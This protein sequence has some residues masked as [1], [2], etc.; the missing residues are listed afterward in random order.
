MKTKI[1]ISFFTICL[2]VLPSCRINT[3]V[4]IATI[5]NNV[6]KK[7]NGSVVL[8]AIFVDTRFTHPWSEYDIKSTLDSIQKAATWIEKKAS[9]NG[10]PVNINVQYHQ[11]KQV[12]PI[13]CEFPNKT[14]SGTLYSPIPKIGVPKLNR[15]ADRIANTAGKSLSP[16]TSGVIKTKN[17]RNDRERLISHLRNMFKTDNVVL[18]YFINNY[19]KEE[20]SLTLHT[21]SHSDIEYS[22]VSFKKPAV[23]AH[24]FL[25]VFGAID[26]Y[27]TPFDRKFSAMRKKATAM[28]E[29]PDEIMSFAYR[30]LDSLNI[31]PFTKYMIGWDNEL[32][33]KYKRILFGKK[34]KVIKY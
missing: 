14:L 24:E 11:N 12:I 32:D 3:A 1:F 2:L 34:I 18:M 25:H 23:I 31:S 15:W 17:R 27:I 26:L 28:K 30:Q 13:A 8:Y 33:E 10:V 22:I 4:Q 29:F 6:C 9:E 20:M 16:D 5:D 19:Y 21:V 7:L